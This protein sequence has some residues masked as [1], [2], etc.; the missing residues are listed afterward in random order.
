RLQRLPRG[1]RA[2]APGG[3]GPGPHRPALVARRVPPL[4][5][6]AAGRRRHARLPGP[7]HRRRARAAARLRPRRADV[8][9]RRG[10]EVTRPTGGLVALAAAATGCAAEHAQS[11]LHP[12]S[13][14]AREI[15]RLWWLMLGVYGAV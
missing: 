13:A 8:P 1:R 12:A 15:S 3:R 14:E 7:D 5:P 9:P 6:R 11:A 4:R 10:G 2:R